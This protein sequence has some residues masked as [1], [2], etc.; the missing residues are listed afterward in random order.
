M[1]EH[2]LFHDRDIDTNLVFSMAYAVFGNGQACAYATTES[3]LLNTILD[4]ATAWYTSQYDDRRLVVPPQPVV[5]LDPEK[6]V[7]RGKKGLTIFGH[8]RVLFRHAEVHQLV[9]ERTDLF[10]RAVEFIGLFVGIQPQKREM[11]EH[12]EYEVE[13]PRTFQ[14]LGE[15]AKCCRELGEGFIYATPEAL[16][17]SL[18]F[19]ANRIFADMMLMSTT[20]DPTRYKVPVETLV[21]NVLTKDSTFSLIHNFMPLIDAFSFHQYYHLL[22]AEM[23]K[24]MRVVLDWENGKWNDMTLKEIVDKHLFGWQDQDNAERLKLMLI[25]WPLQSESS[26]GVQKMPPLLT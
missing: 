8:V 24:S 25:E 21:T 17:G 1:F 23:F 14:I 4:I 22:W 5:R 13:W 11:G 3:K 10:Q 12:V 7:F 20:L 2:Y 18:A 6:T 15:L 26:N 16:L 9:V 19:V